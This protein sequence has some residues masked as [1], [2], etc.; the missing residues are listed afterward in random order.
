MIRILENVLGL[1]VII[2]CIWLVIVFMAV[3]A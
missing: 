3:W 1:T 2:A